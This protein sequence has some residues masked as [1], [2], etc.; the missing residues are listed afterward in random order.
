MQQRVVHWLQNREKGEDN[1]IYLVISPPSEMRPSNLCAKCIFMKWQSAIATLNMYICVQLS[2]CTI[3]H[4]EGENNLISFR[5]IR[6]S[7]SDY[8]LRQHKV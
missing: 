6:F 8:P 3:L 7:E 4:L 2:A 1:I 5:A